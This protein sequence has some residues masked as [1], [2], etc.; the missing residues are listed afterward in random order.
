VDMFTADSLSELD[1]LAFVSKHRDMFSYILSDTEHSVSLDEVVIL[2]GF[3]AYRA[4]D[5]SIDGV[6]QS[7]VNLLPLFESPKDL[8]RSEETLDAILSDPYLKSLIIELK[9][10]SY[11]AGPSD[12]G[13]EGGMFAH[14]NLILAETKAQ[15]ILKKH[16]ANDPRLAGVVLRVLNGLGD[17]FPRRISESRA[18]LYAT[19]QGSAGNKLG[20]PM[21]QVA[22]V[23]SVAGRPSENTCRALEF[24][25]IEKNYPTEF[26]SLQTM[27]NNAV[28]GYQKYKN[29]PASQALFR[30]LAIGGIGPWLNTSSRG[31]SKSAVPTDITKSRAIGLVNY[32]IMTSVFSRIFMSANALCDMP[33]EMQQHLPLLF[34]QST[35]VREIVLKI[36]YSLTISDFPRAWQK[37]RPEGVPSREQIEQWAAEF[38]DAGISKKS[39]HHTLAYL[40]RQSHAVLRA[41]TFFLPPSHQAHAK[42][43]HAAN[44]SLSRPS[45]VLAL[46][47]LSAI[48]VVDPQFKQLAEEI[49][50]DLL[51]RHARLAR[52]LD[53]Y[54]ERPE[55]SKEATENVVLALRGDRNVTAGPKTISKMRVPLVKLSLFQQDEG[56][57]VS[58]VSSLR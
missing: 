27:V 44:A 13:N 17:D 11:V 21:G 53:A 37:I 33:P 23:D 42:A 7:P 47:W 40:E 6:R 50:Y 8:A 12:L 10:F 31:E 35:T 26:A 18:Q 52:C 45:H 9:E 14:I 51:P 43:F 1:V 56:L 36:V 57:D 15:N 58:P 29:N 49:K 3:T 48:G 24:E 19:F 34:E 39:L 2:F 30:A 55:P 22:Y 28:K 41:M 4:G 54:S 20:A 16:Q 25:A 32:E 5:L 46:E 38:D